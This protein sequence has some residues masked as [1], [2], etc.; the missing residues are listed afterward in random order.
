MVGM[1][2]MSYMAIIPDCRRVGC[3]YMYSQPTRL[4]VIIS[5]LSSM[6]MHDYRK[7]RLHVLV[8]MYMYMYMYLCSITWIVLV[9]FNDLIVQKNLQ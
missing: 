2:D 3:E 9:Y 6:G 1:Y 5:S 4:Q 8:F 7:T